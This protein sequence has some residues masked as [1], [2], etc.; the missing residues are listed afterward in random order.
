MAAVDAQTA[1]GPGR[2]FDGSESVETFSSDGPRRIFFEPDGTPI[3]PGDFSST[4]G[5]LLRKPDLAAADHVTTATP[6][7]TAFRGTSAAAPHAAA[8]AA[9]MLEAAGGP[10]NVSPAQLLG[11]MEGAALDIEA[12]GRDRDSGAGIVIAPM[13]VGAVGVAPNRRNRAPTVAEPLGDMTLMPGGAVTADVGPVFADPDGD[14]LTYGVLARDS[15]RVAASLRGS[16]LTLKALVP[17]YS[18]IAVRATDHSGLTVIE[19][20]SVA[21]SVGAEDYDLDN[22]GLI[23]IGNLEQLDAMRYDLDADGVVDGAIWQPYYAAFPAGALEMGCPQNGCS[24][25]EMSADL[26]FDTDGSG[27]PSEGDKFWND[28]AGWEPFGNLEGVF[29]FPYGDAFIGDFHG[30]GHTISNLFI[31]RPMED[32]VGLFGFAW[33]GTI[34]EVGLERVNVTGRDW[35]GGL[36]GYA[37]QFVR[38]NRSYATGRVSG[39][40][41]VGGL[42][43]GGAPR[44]SHCYATVRVSGTGAA[45]GG[46]VGFAGRV[47]FSYATGLVS[48]KDGVGGLA[49]FAFYAVES[50]YSTGR[51]SGQGSDGSRSHCGP[52]GGVGGLIGHACNATIE[53][54]L[55]T[56]PVGG[57]VSVGRLSGSR[58]PEAE[59][60]RSYWDLET[61]GVHVGVDD[62]NSNGVMDEDEVRTAGVLGQT[63]GGLQAPTGYEGLYET[64]RGAQDTTERHWHFGTQAQ[65]PVLVADMDGDGEATWEEF[66][67]QLREGPRLSAASAR[68]QGRV[69]LNWTAVDTSHWTPAPGVTYTVTRD[70]GDGTETL[71]ADLTTLEY[72]DTR[73][74]AGEVY[75]YQ[76]TAVVQ[77]GEATRS[78]FV[79]VKAGTANHVPLAVG[80]LP[81]QTLREGGRSVVVDVSGAF[82]DPDGD[83]LTYG[84]SSSS[85]SAML[86]L[87][88]A[89]VEIEPVT[90]GKA[91]ITVTATDVGG[92]NAAATQRFSVTVWSRTDVDYDRDDD[93]LIEITTVAQLGAMHHDLDGN[94]IVDGSRFLDGTGDPAAYAEAFPRAARPRRCKRR[95]T[96]AASLRRGIWIWTTTVQLTIHGISARL[97][98]SRP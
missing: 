65:Y 61:S 70:D 60:R 91:G 48:G 89:I 5:R 88:G 43:G 24:G 69:D 50:S 64:W 16:T 42:V 86:S 3:T 17:G 74:T 71:A 78:R 38:F 84:A 52:F 34:L 93:G 33:N 94:G 29:S 82:Q 66:G 28:G 83:R 41:R 14:G 9:L 13:G 81:D 47:H 68:G 55:A 15:L 23:E 31:D 75:T 37:F 1:G 56:G 32:G 45:I 63:T 36:A 57:R 40:E 46:L 76:V 79:S 26:D 6:G 80:T 11:A 51:V 62:R 87:S 7:F 12:A 85:P 8:L 21:V 20:F 59:F 30:N 58:R 67:Y 39:N 54:S 97:P 22:D 96:T 90:A 49:G 77:G 27:G 18:V 72:A 98:S 25:Y 2:A 35:V 92:S 10:N 4:G 53:K 73:V 19:R 44:V 95:A